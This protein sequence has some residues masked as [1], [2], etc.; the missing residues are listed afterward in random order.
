MKNKT[1]NIVQ[2][3][4]SF[5][6]LCSLALDSFKCN[7]Y[8]ETY[9]GYSGFIKSW[10]KIRGYGFTF[11]QGR[12]FY[13]LNIAVALSV[14]ILILCIITLSNAKGNVLLAQPS[15]EKAAK[16]PLTIL[17]LSIINLLFIFTSGAL[18]TYTDSAFNDTQK[19]WY[20]PAFPFYLTIAILT[21]SV[22]TSVLD[23]Y[24]DTF[25]SAQNQKLEIGCSSVQWKSSD[26]DSLTVQSINRKTGHNVAALFFVLILACYVA[27][28]CAEYFAD[29]LLVCGI[30]VSALICIA[31][32]FLYLS[33]KKTIM[34]I[35]KHEIS[36]RT[37]HHQNVQIPFSSI[38]WIQVSESG[39]FLIHTSRGDALFRN[40]SQTDTVIKA[41]SE[42]SVSEPTATE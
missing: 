8:K 27:W 25:N 10:T 18:N 40:M 15:K 19:S 24:M 9:G 14:V 22:L 2:V 36:G 3:I 29:E 42:L 6:F 35:S 39:S 16:R 32:L 17:V 12:E 11:H 13:L 20:S 30:I 34:T 21:I 31:S 26:G 41:L 7:V 4:T 38:E 28:E 1:L 37:S 5:L 23:V 33:N